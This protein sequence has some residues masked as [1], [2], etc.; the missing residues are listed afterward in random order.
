M[1]TRPTAAAALCACALA[2]A[3]HATVTTYNFACVTNT[4]A[5]NA[6]AGS[7]QLWVDVEDTPTP[8]QVSFTFHNAG[9]LPCSITDIYFDDGTLLGIASIVNS[10]GVNF[11]QG[12]SPPNLPGGN[13]VTPAF[14]TTAGFLADSS[15]PAQPNGVNPG[16]WV[17]ITFNLINGQSYADSITALNT[18][19]D[20]LR[21]GIHVQGFSNG[22]SESFVNT[23]PA[24]AGL[25]L[26]GLMP[27]ARRRRR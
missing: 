20:H 19:G 18:P 2:T 26:L 10:A 22:G 24:P 13:N 12:A 3:A 16:E 9:P 1:R 7:A 17:K 15:P 23:I 6:L 27:L 11:G 5:A 21:I 8:G 4:T 25:C 14:Q